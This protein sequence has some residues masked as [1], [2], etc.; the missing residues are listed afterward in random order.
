MIILFM[1]TTTYRERAITERITIRTVENDQTRRS[2]NR[3]DTFENNRT[4]SHDNHEKQ[5][6]DNE[7]NQKKDRP[8]EK[9]STDEN[10][11]LLGDFPYLKNEKAWKKLRISL[12]SGAACFSPRNT[13]RPPPLTILWLFQFY[14]IFL[15]IRPSN[16]S[17]IKPKNQ[18]EER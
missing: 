15:L 7:K 12:P 11:V 1:K 2:K 6:D 5:K 9:T 8:D 18:R 14:L 10:D 4:Q 17:K 16:L 13:S 3:E